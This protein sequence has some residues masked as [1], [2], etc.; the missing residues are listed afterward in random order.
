MLTYQRI[1]AEG[2]KNLGI[3][4]ESQI[5][6]A[7]KLQEKSQSRLSQVLVELGYISNDDQARQ[8]QKPGHHDCST[9]RLSEGS[10]KDP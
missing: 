7:L 3:L 2:L 10:A 6:E 5:Q 1:I 9:E 4:K 8:G